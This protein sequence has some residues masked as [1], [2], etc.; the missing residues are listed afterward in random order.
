VKIVNGTFMRNGEIDIIYG[1]RGSK[2]IANGIIK[3][4]VGIFDN[5]DPKILAF[6]NYHDFN[7]REYEISGFN[8]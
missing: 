6:N 4:R 2:H 7:H 5:V 8:L 1:S 3:V